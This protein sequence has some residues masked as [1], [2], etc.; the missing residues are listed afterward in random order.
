MV[1]RSQIYVWLLSE[2]FATKGYVCV[3]ADYRLRRNAREDMPGAVRDAAEDGRMALE[4]VKVNGQ[5][6]GIDTTRLALGGGS[7][8]GFLVGNLVHD[9][10]RPISAGDVF[11]VLSL[12]G[13]PAKKEGRLFEAVQPAAPPTLLLHGTAD[14]LIPHQASEAFALELDAAGI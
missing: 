10:E 7:A 14:Q 3:S 5:A 6:H 9:P 13:P 8:G 11:A 2:Y 12:W 1:A 4:W